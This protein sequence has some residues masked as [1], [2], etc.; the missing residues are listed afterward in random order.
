MLTDSD[1]QR[2]AEV[3]VDWTSRASDAGL[4]MGIRGFESRRVDGRFRSAL[5]SWPRSSERA[6]TRRSAAGCG[7]IG[8]C[9]G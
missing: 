9:P 2:V 4:G 5:T 1:E 7:T 3:G 6:A 8:G